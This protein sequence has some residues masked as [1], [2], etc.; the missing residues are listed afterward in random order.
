[1]AQRKKQLKV[2]DRYINP[3]RILTAS[4]EQI[5][6]WDAA[7]EA[8]GLSWSEWARQVMDQAAPP[9]RKPSK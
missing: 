9:L 4:Q 7:A 6:R 2:A 1:M 5:N 3:R 8:W